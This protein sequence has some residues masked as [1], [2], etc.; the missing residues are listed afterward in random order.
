MHTGLVAGLGA[1]II[2]AVLVIASIGKAQE[3]LVL[4]QL[5]GSVS[6]RILNAGGVR[7]EGHYP[8]MP[9]LP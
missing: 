1:V 6:V 9:K 2:G 7:H 8:R 5:W 3:T 4:R